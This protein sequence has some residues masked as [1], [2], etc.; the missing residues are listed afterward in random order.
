MEL[1][2]KFL[3]GVLQRFRPVRGWG[4]PPAEACNRTVGAVRSAA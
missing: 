4:K 2:N 3:P 1:Q